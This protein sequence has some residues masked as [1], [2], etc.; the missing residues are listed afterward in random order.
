MAFSCASMIGM[1]MQIENLM[2]FIKNPNNIYKPPNPVL[3]LREN[4]GAPKHELNIVKGRRSKHAMAY[5]GGML[6]V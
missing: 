5:A 2:E 3:A 6:P 4:L 1:S